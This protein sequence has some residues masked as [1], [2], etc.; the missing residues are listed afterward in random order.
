[1]EGVVE[2]GRWEG[3]RF[4]SKTHREPWEALEQEGW[5]LVYTLKLQTGVMSF[6]PLP[7]DPVVSSPP[8]RFMSS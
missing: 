6:L 7:C 4:F 3:M 8:L 5:S 2:G 1:M